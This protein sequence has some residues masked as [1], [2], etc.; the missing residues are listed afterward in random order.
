MVA[1][2][3]LGFKFETFQ[4]KVI[5]LKLDAHANGFGKIN[6]W[7]FWS[8]NPPAINRS[9]LLFLNQAAHLKTSRLTSCKELVSLSSVFPTRDLENC[10]S[11]DVFHWECCKGD[12]RDHK[13][14]AS[15]SL[16]VLQIK[17]GEE[18][19]QRWRPLEQWPDVDTWPCVWNPITEY[20]RSVRGQ[21]REGELTLKENCKG[22]LNQ[23][24]ETGWIGMRGDLDSKHTKVKK[25][26]Q[27]WEG[28]RFTRK[29]N[30]RK[31]MA[32]C[33]LCWILA[34]IATAN[35]P[36]GDHHVQTSSS[37]WSLQDECH[38]HHQLSVHPSLVHTTPCWY[39][40]AP[41]WFKIRKNMRIGIGMKKNTSK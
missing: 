20:Q 10:D 8:A 29:W 14:M 9:K 15:Q 39:R 21:K 5:L 27:N 18:R 4:N 23:G 17:R 16:K 11:C 1:S 28:D 36:G 30:S 40:E 6:F 35:Y 19:R 22:N 31:K 25:R 13:L 2:A 34:F 7:F 33:T 32:S 26:G 24:L 12:H 3:G 41:I 37:L 38:L